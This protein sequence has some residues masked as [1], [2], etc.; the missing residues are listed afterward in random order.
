MTD[1]LVILEGTDEALL[2]HSKVVNLSR[3]HKGQMDSLRE[4]MTRPT[5]GNIGLI[6]ADKSVWSELANLDELVTMARD[7]PD[8]TTSA[9]STRLVKLY[10]EVIGRR[11]HVSGLGVRYD[12]LFSFL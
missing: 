9:M 4:Y 11:I 5:M 10:H 6:G 8:G 2:L 3:P 7:T 1:T 12:C